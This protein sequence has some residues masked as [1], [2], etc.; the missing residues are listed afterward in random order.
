MYKTFV[1]PSGLLTAF[2]LLLVFLDGIQV[3]GVKGT[4]RFRL[5][6]NAFLYFLAM[7]TF[8]LPG[9][10]ACLVVFILFFQIVV[11][12]SLIVF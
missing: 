11:C 9:R 12:H 5:L 4:D 7:F 8:P 10:L 2:F 1:P 3:I 6:G